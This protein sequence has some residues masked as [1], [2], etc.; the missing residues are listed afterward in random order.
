MK[1]W[2]VIIVGAGAGGLSSALTLASQGKSVL[3]LEAGRDPG[4]KMGRGVVDGVEFDTGPSVLTMTDV[5]S[6]V[7]ESA[8]QSMGDYVELMPTDGFRYLWPDG[9]DFTVRFDLEDTLAEVEQKFG[10]KHAGEFRAFMAYTRDI[11]DAA[12]PNFV[13]GDAPTMGSAA[14]LGVTKFRE[15]L[16]IDPMRTMGKAIDSRVTEPHLRDLL[17]RYATYNGSH[18]WR[19]PAT[20]NCIAWVE[21]GLGCY[22]VK[23]GIFALASGME[24]AAVEVGAS[25]EY[26]AKVEEIVAERGQITGV[27]LAGG[28]FLPAKN[29]ICNADVAHLVTSLMP[30][31]KSVSEPSEPSMSGWTGVLRTKRVERHSHAVLFPSRPYAQE[32]VDIFDRECVP[33]D[34][35][36]YLCAQEKAHGRVGWQDDEAVF[37]MINAPPVQGGAAD[38]RGV[39][40]KIHARLLEFDLI[41]SNAEWVW[42]RTP[43]QLAQQFEGSHGSIYGASSN[44]QF[45]AF[46]RPPNRIREVSGLFLASGSAHPGGGVPMCLLSG[47]AAARAILS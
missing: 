40:E 12:A 7:F 30:S 19:A 33:S 15:L 21:L 25:F 10:T 8:G 1:V 23:G 9:T 6:S 18:P 43:T 2:D 3:V 22:G 44:S 41:D 42:T 38:T 17:A 46:Q 26:E 47:Q 20:L 36:I 16:K 13:Y 35:T 24:R 29:V 4:G 14:K 28:R 11:W 32:F 31:L 34:P 39:A 27:K 45:S 37:A 5:L